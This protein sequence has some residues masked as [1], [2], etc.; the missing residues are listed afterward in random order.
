MLNQLLTTELTSIDIY[1]V[2]SRILQNKGYLKL[3]ENLN[4]EMEDEQGHAA[5]IIER[6]IFLEGSP[7]VHKREAFTIEQDVV[8]MFELD[9]NYEMD[10]RAKLTDGIELCLKLK[11]YVT[12]EIL[13]SLLIDTEEDHI[14]WLE[15]Q[16]SIIK[17]IGRERYL[18]EKI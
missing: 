7:E 17:D 6:I 15:T 18:A 4:H 9:L 12:K 8:K 5:K 14:D 3:Y 10:V 1:F 11:D 2:Q 13:E 16:L